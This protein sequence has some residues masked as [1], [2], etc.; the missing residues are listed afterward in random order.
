[1]MQISQRIHR[2]KTKEKATEP[3]NLWPFKSSHF[4]GAA[5][6]EAGRQGRKRRID[7]GKRKQLPQGLSSPLKSLRTS[8]K[9]EKWEPEE[10]L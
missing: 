6:V 3:D 7:M 8:G 4:R 9:I 5:S 1:M 2:R 10:G